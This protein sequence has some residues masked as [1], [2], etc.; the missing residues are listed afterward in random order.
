MLEGYI[1]TL[2]GNDYSEKRAKACVKSIKK[3]ASRIDPTIF[4]ATTPETFEDHCSMVF[5]KVLEYTWPKRGEE[6]I[7]KEYGIKQHG[8][9][10][11]S[12]DTIKACFMSHARLWKKCVK[13]KYPLVILEHDAVFQRKFEFK[14]LVESGFFS[15]AA[16]INSPL[17]CTRKS[18]LYHQTIS[19]SKGLHPIPT[20]DEEAFPPAH[21]LP[22]N[23]AYVITPTFA[24]TLIDKTK[25]VG[26]WPNDALMCRQIFGSLLYCY[27]PYF[28]TVNQT[29]STSQGR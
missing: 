14:E 12:I 13:N 24:Q 22:G 7:N 9:S 25:E 6:R 29:R 21:G 18:M 23:S 5:G 19:Q 3:T 11:D 15:G 1:I 4:K 20:L 2:K 28:T 27:Y 10:T 17:G 16:S 26:I 8:Y